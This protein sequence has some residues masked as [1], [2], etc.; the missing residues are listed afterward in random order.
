[1]IVLCSPHARKSQYVNDEIRHF[2]QER[3]KENIIP[4]LVSGVP[5]NEA[6][7][8]QEQEKAFPEALSELMEMP[9]A[10]NYLGFDSKKDKVNKGVFYGTWYKILAD[11]YDISR[12]EIEERDK[13]RKARQRN[14]LIGAVSAAF[15]VV[16]LLAGW[17]EIQRRKF[18]NYLE[19]ATTF[20][21]FEVTD[22]TKGW[23]DQ[24][25]LA[26]ETLAAMRKIVSDKWGFRDV[27]ILWFDDKP[28]LSDAAKQSFRN[29]M[30]GVGVSIQE[31]ND[32]SV[33]KKKVIDEKFDLVIANYGSPKDRFAY[34]VLSEIAK[35]GLN[36]PVVIY[37]LIPNP[38]FAREARCYGAVARATTIETLFPAVMRALAADSRPGISNDQLQKCIE[39][40]I[41]P[42]NT[43]AWQQWL[44]ETKAGRAA[45]MPE[46]NRDD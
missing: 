22:V 20:N 13:K 43:P 9:L 1:M 40:E 37:S 11:L 33:V 26:N 38:S 16:S 27:K 25:T 12:N 28:E 3:G 42:Y 14:I 6:K 45:T 29:G 2:A 15:V 24:R 30:Q 35:H 36:T 5:N 8:E 18:D 21:A 46:V 19:L 34:Q 41:M 17:A 44:E 7:L 10:A 39:E 4:V 31:E 23:D 32:I